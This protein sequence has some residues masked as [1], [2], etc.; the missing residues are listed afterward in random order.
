MYTHKSVSFSHLDTHTKLTHIQTRTHTHI[1]AR[2]HWRT[3]STHTH[4]YTHARAEVSLKTSLTTGQVFAR[5]PNARKSR[6]SFCQS[7]S[8]NSVTS[9]A[10][11]QKITVNAIFD[12]FRHLSQLWPTLKGGQSKI[13]KL[14]YQT[15]WSQ[16]SLLAVAQI[17]Q[18]CFTG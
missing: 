16:W 8:T 13:T 14:V 2:T 5:T 12:L 4:T 3:Q 6:T 17:W 1:P 15:R 18:S 7:F 9:A 10:L 11:A